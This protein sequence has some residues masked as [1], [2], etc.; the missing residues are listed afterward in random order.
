MKSSAFL[1]TVQSPIRSLVVSAYTVPT[2]FPESDGTL[3]WSKTTI[4]IVEASA[5]GTQ[6]LGYTYADPVTAGLIRN[7][8]SPMIVGSD[9]MNV[10]GTWLSMLRAIRNLGGP[11]LHRRRSPPWT[12]RC[13]T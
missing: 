4:V 5:D 13:G 6:G 12:M 2:D 7:L 11:V 8:L 10:M 9:A 1:S 3:Q